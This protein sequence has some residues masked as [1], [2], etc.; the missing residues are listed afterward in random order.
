[1]YVLFIFKNIYKILLVDYFV[2]EI[3]FFLYYLEFF[4]IFLQ[5]EFYYNFFVF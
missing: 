5:M 1:M 4:D 3:Y 2:Q